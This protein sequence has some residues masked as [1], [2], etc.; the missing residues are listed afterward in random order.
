M[1]QQSDYW[2]VALAEAPVLVEIPADR[3]RSV[4][5][6]SPIATVSTVLD[7]MTCSGLMGLVERSGAEQHELLLAA[8]ILLLQR[9]SAQ[10]VV[11]TGVVVAGKEHVIPLCVSLD[12]SKTAA[13]S[14]RHVRSLLAEATLHSSQLPSL[15]VNHPVIKGGLQLSFEVGKSCARSAQF[16]GRELTLKVGAADSDTTVELEYATGLFDEATAQRYL[17]YWHNLLQ[18]MVEQAEMPI[19]AMGLMTSAEQSQL[20][21]EW[22]Q[23]AQADLVAAPEL[24]H[25]LFEAQVLRTPQAIAVSTHTEAL[26]YT[27]L[28]QKANQL[29]RCLRDLGVG[30]DD[31]VAICL[32]RSLDMA[33]AVLAV[34][35]AGGAYVPLD[36]AYPVERLGYMIEDSAP[37]VLLTQQILRSA[38]VAVAAGVHVLVLGDEAVFADRDTGNLDAVSMG[39]TADHMAYLIYTSGST[40]KPKGVMVQHAGVCH[41]LRW[42]AETYAPVS[43]SVVSSSLAFDATVTSL[44]APWL[45]GGEVHLLPEKGEIDGL[46]AWIR[47][48]RGNGLVK[49]TPSHLDALGQQLLASGE[50]SQVGIFVVGGEALSPATVGLWR[51]IQPGVRIVNEYGPTETVVGCIVYDVPA[52]YE[53]TTNVPIGRPIAGATV[54]ILDRCGLPVPQGIVGEV[55]IGGVGVTRGYLGREDLTESRFVPD[56][57]SRRTGA[58]RYSTG[59]LAR[60]LPDGSLEFLGRNDFQVKIRGFRIELGEIEARLLEH[61]LVASAVVMARGVS[62]EDMRLVAYLVPKSPAALIDIDGILAA[63]R[64][65][66]PDYMVP[67]VMMVLDVLPVTPNGKL[68]REVLPEPGNDRPDLATAYEPP[69]NQDE[70][71]V[72]AAFATVL[73]IEKVGR[74]DNFFD[75]GGNSL[76]AM[77]LLEHARK[78]YAQKYPIDVAD[79]AGKARPGLSATVFFRHPTPAALVATLSVQGDGALESKRM[80]R[81]QAGTITEANEPIALIAMAG[82]FPGADDVEAFWENLCE[83]RDSITLFTPDQLDPWVSQSDREDP[84]YVMA[85]GVIEN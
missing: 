26:S 73:G 50:K 10:S 19:G 13:N 7:A 40:G 1:T 31:R 8:W 41:Y 70:A 42:A 75:L 60:W 72:C 29:A 49:I 4:S 85:R 83:G 18:A 11:L 77:R 32:E 16:A 68:D 12:A 6:G 55:H 76:L 82:R 62:A 69:I 24:V 47:S 2:E 84:N 78:S 56:T 65:Q 80:G 66:L 39:L 61:A 54:Y 45:L 51:H 48:P 22:S 57:F 27:A 36:P 43:S 63:L 20:L 21:S 23:V 33:I 44:F 14:V 37:K 17:G 38:L 9:L 30:P 58:R 46:H 28:N 53:A 35:K 34:L 79:G 59:D 74:H 52:V 81:G 67:S 64:N 5:A 25:R 71:D 15:E 3:L